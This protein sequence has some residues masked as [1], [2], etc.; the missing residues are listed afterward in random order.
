VPLEGQLPCNANRAGESF[1]TQNGPSRF[2]RVVSPG[3]NIL[4]DGK[5]ASVRN[6]VLVV[7][8]ESRITLEG[9]NEDRLTA[10][11]IAREVLDLVRRPAASESKEH[12]NV[13]GSHDLP[14]HLPPSLELFSRKL[15]QGS[16][17]QPGSVQRGLQGNGDWVTQA[18]RGVASTLRMCCQLLDLL[19]IGGA[20]DLQLDSDVLE[21]S[22]RVI[23]VIFRGVA[24]SSANVS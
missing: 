10:D 16:G 22:R 13:R 3:A 8:E 5:P 7:D 14:H 9:K 23:D 24:E 15:S 12:I 6:V 21:V 18:L 20:D 4:E 19:G 2:D 17:V 1:L 11:G